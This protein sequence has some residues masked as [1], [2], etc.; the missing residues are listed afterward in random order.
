MI[1]F[2]RGLGLALAVVFLFI[3]GALALLG[4]ARFPGLMGLLNRG[5]GAA[6]PITGSFTLQDA[7]TGRAFTRS[8]LRD[9]W[10]LLYFGY[11]FCPDICPTDLA[12]EVQALDLMGADGNRITPVFITVDPARDTPAVL[13]RYVALFSPRLIGLTGS[14]AE[15]SAAERAFRVYAEKQPIPNGGGAYLMN[16]SAFFYLM[17]PAGA[18]AA[19]LPPDLDAKAMADALRRSLGTA[20]PAA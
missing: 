14:P 13:A 2:L 7:A 4:P 15:I 16:H 18:V 12:K 19:I 10:T 8:D 6:F 3:G 20:A 1:R 17:N 9:G 11:T 5:G